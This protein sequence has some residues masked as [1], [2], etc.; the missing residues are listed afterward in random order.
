MFFVL[1]DAGLIVSCYFSPLRS[2]KDVVYENLMRNPVCEG[3]LS[4][5]FHI[6]FQVLLKILIMLSVAVMLRLRSCC[7]C[8]GADNRCINVDVADLEDCPEVTSTLII[9]IRI[10][11]KNCFHLIVFCLGHQ[12]M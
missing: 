6:G 7:D 2:L 1:L 3:S 10:Q 4:H 11:K 12:Y 9:R 8:G 5:P